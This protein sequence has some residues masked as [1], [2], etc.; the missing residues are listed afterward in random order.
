MRLF[1]PCQTVGDGLDLSLLEGSVQEELLDRALQLL[2][3]AGAKCLQLAH[4][5]LGSG[6]DC[7]QLLF[8]LKAP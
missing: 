3:K 5:E 7:E 4:V 6:T 2:S 8:D 1:P